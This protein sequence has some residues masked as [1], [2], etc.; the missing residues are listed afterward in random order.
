MHSTHKT[1]IDLD[2]HIGFPLKLLLAGCLFLISALGFSGTPFFSTLSGK[3]GL[4]SNVIAA[5]AQT[6]NNFLWIGTAN[7]LARYDGYHFKVFKKNE[8]V[9]SLPSNQISCLMADGDFLWVGTWNGLCKI[10]TRTFEI[11]RID[12]KANNVIR[13]LYKDPR[14]H[15]YWIGTETGL[16]HYQAG[17]NSFKIYN[18]KNSSISHNTVRT[19]LQDKHGNLWIGTYD[20]LNK[21]IRGSELFVVI[22]LKKDYKPS[23]KNNLICDIKQAAHSDTLL[24]VGTETGLCQVNTV[25]GH[26]RHFSEKNVPFSNEVIKYIYT[27]DHGS[28][29]LGTD[30]GLNVFDPE[31][32]SN[33]VHF[34]N[35]QISYSIANNVIWQIFEDSGGVIWFVTSNGISRLNKYRNFYDYHEVSYRLENQA[36]GNQVKSVLITRKGIIWLATLHGVIRI[37]PAKKQKNVFDTSSPPETRI[38]LNN[39]FTLE[40]DQYDRVWIGTAGGINIWDEPNRKMYS[41]TSNATNGLKT[42]YI[43][44]FLKGSDGS[45]WVSAWEGGL[46]KV[47]GDFRILPSLHFRLAGEYGSERSI[48]GSD[49]IWII[50]YNELYRID[51]KTFVEKRIDAFSTVANKKDVHCL[52]YSENGSLWAG[53]QNGLIEYNPRNDK[54]EFHPIITGTDI[55]IGNLVEDVDGNIWGAVNNSVIKFAVSGHQLEIFPLDKDLPLKSFFY[56]C[57]ARLPSGEIIFGGDNGYISLHPKNVVPNPY[58][59]EVYVTAVEIN[60]K[61]IT[62]GDT[63][64]TRNDISF[65]NSLRLKYAQRSIAFEFSSLHYWQP[66]MNVYAYKLVGFDKSWN[67][68]SGQK[69][70]AVYPNLSA[71]DYTFVVR[72][73][74]NYGIWSDKTASIHIVIDPPLFLNPFFLVLY[75]FAIV[76]MIY[77]GLRTYSTRLHLKNELKITRMEKEHGE[78]LFRAK[79]QFFTNISH[80]LRTP[81]S[82]ILPPI[83]QALKHGNLDKQNQQLITL[84]E[85]NSYRLLRVVNQILDFRKLENDTLQLKIT[86]VD[87]ISFC[88]DLF[89]LFTD[90]ANRKEIDYSFTSNTK[91][92]NA[93]IDTEKMETV[94]FNLL[95]NAFKFTQ[96]GGTINLSVSTLPGSDRYPKGSVEITVSDTGI[97]IDAGEKTKI[98]QPFY[99]ARESQHMEA[100]TGI[101]LALAAEYVKLHHGRIDVESTKGK[102]TCFTV[103][104]PLDSSHFPV[105]SIYEEQ[106]I[107]QLATKSTRVEDHNDTTYRFGIKSDKPLVLIIDDSADMTDFICASLKEKY[108]F[109]VA[110]NGEEGLQKASSFLPEVIV[111][112]VMMPVMDGLNLC[113][114][115]KENSKT[116]HIS[117]ILLT[118]KS[119]TS[120]KIE[121]IKMGA[122]VYITKPF[123][124]EFL[125][126]NIDH[127]LARKKELADYFK[128]ELVIQP[129]TDHGKENMDDKFIKKVMNIIEANIADPNFGVEML[130]DEI[131]MSSTHLYRKLKSLTQLSANEIIRKYRIKKASLLLKNKEGN[132]SEIMYDVGFSNLSYF[133]KCFRAE[134]GV[135]PK[136]YQQKMSKS[137]VDIKDQL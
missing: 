58:N 64:L 15:S 73:T 47:E 94:L 27:D 89:L 41:I 129:S 127:L 60:N 124:I 133:S 67:Y 111:S 17:S 20:K 54:A 43:A 110:E 1:I 123:E 11:A 22:D 25:T 91:A 126:A 84:A 116:S 96:K 33:T 104:L 36:V 21:L 128:N 74:N 4:P 38:L 45:F 37:D 81:I 117:I 97:G 16:I 51:P 103:E 99:Q 119:L 131:G 32:L 52:Y 65:T 31:T 108:N 107:N 78:E 135:S 66:S 69:N 28:L 10:N 93:R 6:G 98:F 102:G 72:G 18:T 63:V 19:I 14:D 130:S 83:H 30:F 42:N 106:E 121:G 87:I 44:K 2:S 100:G 109:I 82:L 118:A 101:G 62:T 132:I 23:L 70:F 57:T 59:P 92:I 3:D 113:K 114:K 39:V 136:E 8:S 134:F 115:I 24:W 137:S 122:D 35:P 85:K 125:E 9:Q 77:F 53:S 34:H 61:P 75:S 56:G 46:F 49:A 86:T 48:A 5:V 105:D 13:A 71:G 90:K 76:A 88:H 7:G 26:F 79:Q 50:R 68:V 55:N 95:S 12:L 120:Q 112:D 40:E 29:W 80:E